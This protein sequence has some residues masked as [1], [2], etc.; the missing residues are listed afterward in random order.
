M[1]TPTYP[2]NTK[3]REKVIRRVL[4]LLITLPLLSKI[5]IAASTGTISAT[6]DPCVING[7]LCTSTI[8]WHVS[9]VTQ[10]FVRVSM[11]GAPETSFS[12]GFDASGN[13]QTPAPWIQAGHT[14]E[15]R[16]YNS[17]SDCAT[18]I[19]SS[20]AAITVS[21]ISKPWPAPKPMVGMNKFDLANQYTG[22]ASG[23]DGGSA[24]R[25]VTT[26]MAEKAI[27]DAAYFGNTYL[28][29]GVTGYGP[30]LYN[31]AG[32]LDQWRTN[33]TA[34]WALIDKMMNDLAS[35]GM[36]IVPNFMWN[37]VQMPAMTGENA[38]QMITDPTSQSYRLL[39][40]YFSDF[41]GRYKNQGTIY[42]YDLTSELNLLADLDNV[43]ACNA[44]PP[45]WD[46]QKQSCLPLGNFSTD[47]MITFTTRLAA[48]VRTLDSGHPISS[49]FSIPRSSAEHLRA[50]PGWVAGGDW[51]LDT[52]AQLQKNLSDVH[53]GLDIVE[54][55]FYNMGGD[56][57]R[58]GVTGSMN[59]GLL[60]IIKP[61]TDAIGKP[62]FIGEFGDAGP[63]DY[64]TTTKSED[65]TA[66][67]TQN[68]LTKISLLGIPY[69]APWVWEFYQL[70]T[71]QIYESAADG[72]SLEPGYT[73]INNTAIRQANINLGN[74]APPIQTPDTSPPTVVLT[75]P[76]DGT[77][78]A[79]SQQLYAVAS[80]NNGTVSKV[81]F[82]VDG[83][84]KGTVSSPPYQYQLDTTKIPQGQH[85]IQAKAYDASSN[86]ALSTASVT[87]PVGLPLSPG[88]IRLKSSLKAKLLMA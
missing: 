1:A 71:H 27:G 23:G 7:S 18:V 67:F 21:A 63:Y 59:A 85:Y 31:S 58:F 60:D 12:C 79:A 55:H 50:T 49:G 66:L 56:N 40:K 24:Y 68:V 61:Q 46:P 45:S 80:D 83:I 44:N 8:T 6:P 10:A 15:F 41:I 78:M 51:T 19:G 32:D 20:I 4:G 84:L 3:I 53:Q 75:W 88:T 72:F 74:S 36:K 25:T 54:I 28:R 48:Y 13:G 81:E 52:Q 9:N 77:A 86:T 16:L 73:P 22:L 29:V 14:Y 5:S 43:G 34:Y 42:F 17:A 39:Q 62:L 2:V 37:W 64:N 30:V 69:S 65:P 76:M 47:E 35:K 26:A 33:P 57:D 87:A 11:D 82:W 70:S 38:R